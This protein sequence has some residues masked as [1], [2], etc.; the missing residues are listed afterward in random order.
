MQ[1]YGIESRHSLTLWNK[2][3]EFTNNYNVLELVVVSPCFNQRLNEYLLSTK[4][5]YIL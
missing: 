4:N 3:N 5:S 2:L 1:E